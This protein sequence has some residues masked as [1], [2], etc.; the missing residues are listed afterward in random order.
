MSTNAIDLNA[1]GI[2]T[3]ATGVFM[4]YE[5]PKPRRKAPDVLRENDG[6]HQLVGYLGW[7]TILTRLTARHS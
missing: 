4:T 6:R 2:A 7:K 5:V 3:T 1:T